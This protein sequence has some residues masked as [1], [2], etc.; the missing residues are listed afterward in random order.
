[1]KRYTSLLL[2]AGLT[3]C[4]ANAARQQSL[5]DFKP[6]AAFQVRWHR[7]IG[8]LG[9]AVDYSKAPLED[10]A[11]VRWY[12]TPDYGS[13]GNSVLQ[14]AVTAD[15]VYVT[16]V[17]GTLARLDPHTGKQV[18]R[19]ACGFP[20][21]GGVGAGAGMVLVG[22][23]KGEVAAFDEAGKLRWQ[24]KVSS[25]VLSVPQVED[26]LV[27]V[28]SGD[29]RITGLSAADG[30]RQWLYERTAPPL[31]VRSSAGVTIRNGTIYAGFAGGKLAAVELASGN[32]KWEAT[33]SEPRGTTEL[34]RI[35]DLTSKVW[36]DDTS[37]CAVSFQGRIGC[38][39]AARGTP[40]WSRE[41]SSDKGMAPQDN[42]FYVALTSGEVLSVDR[43]SG[44]SQW[45]NELFASH[46][47][48][49]PAVLGEYLVLG[50][51][52]GRVYAL[53]Q[54]DGSLAARLT[55]DG[56]AILAAPVALDGGL[57]VTTRNGGL[58]SVEL[59]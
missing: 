35:S 27:V 34:E 6:S 10:P 13:M 8:V 59:R 20:V 46:Q 55:T 23:V 17:K 58:Y 52:Q 16:N 36:V 49:A 19:I 41:M 24:T 47:A 53:K 3:G 12:M 57:L 14:P 38:F 43:T 50:D 5:D 39:D 33:L 1:M 21:A 42:Y 48:A 51:R 37:A 28:R 7:N 54:K 25:E 18:W 44:S 15:A 2:L 22:G 40:L 45:K 32:I 30:K 56:S 26:G 31:G 29:S 9:N 11:A 4:A